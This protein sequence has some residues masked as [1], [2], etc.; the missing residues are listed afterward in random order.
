M[1]TRQLG[2]TW[3]GID[4]ERADPDCLRRRSSC[5][6]KGYLGPSPLAFL[7][8]RACEQEFR[9][10]KY[11]REPANSFTYLT[12]VSL[13]QFRHIQSAGITASEECFEWREVQE[14]LR[15]NDH[16]SS[17]SVRLSVSLFP[18]KSAS[19]PNVIYRSVEPNMIQLSKQV[20]PDFCPL[21]G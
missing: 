18:Q 5:T 6:S 21:H 15:G 11:R 3:I 1:G 2:A 17:V 14:R 19:L 4:R 16:Y 20:A 12:R 9:R 7:R 10:W 13:V 8:A